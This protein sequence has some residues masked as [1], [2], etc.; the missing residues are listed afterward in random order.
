M[1]ERIKDLIKLPDGVKSDRNFDITTE[2]GKKEYCQYKCDIYNEIVGSLNERDGYDCPICKNNGFIAVPAKADYGN[3]YWYEENQFCKCYKVRSTIMRL[4]KSG[5]KNI[6]KDYTFKNFAADTEWQKAIKEAAIRFVQDED[7]SW[8]FIGGTSGCVDGDTE[9]FDGKSWRR[10]ADYDGKEVLQYDASTGKASLTTPYR[11]I[12]K[13]ADILYEISTS[14]GSISQCLSDDHDFAYVTSKGH[15]AK[16][17]FSDVME[18]HKKSLLGFSGRIETAFSYGGEGIP[19]TNSEIRLMCAVIADGSF[20]NGLNLCTVNVKKE[21]KK[22]RLRHLLE[23]KQYKE[24]IKS[25]GY[26]CFR[27]YAPVRE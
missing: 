18:A 5:L 14:R 2:E 24:Y 13:D 9:Y 22:E 23:G 25:N 21:R 1:T 17:R 27:F 15:M 7:H 8:F 11:Y 19:L 26:S 16:K 3:G 20:S 12:E 4:K 6:I 10:I